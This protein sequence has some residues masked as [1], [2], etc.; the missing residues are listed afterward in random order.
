MGRVPIWNKTPDDNYYFKMSVN[1]DFQKERTP[2]K[3]EKPEDKAK[4]DKEFQDKANQLAERLKTEKEF[5]KWVY[6]VPR[7]TVEPML[8]ER[9]ELLAEKKEEAKADQAP[10]FPNSV[11]SPPVQVPFRPPLQAHGN[12]APYPLRSAR[13]RFHDRGVDIRSLRT[14]RNR[15]PRER[16]GH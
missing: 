12:K 14:G 5:E 16:S 4:L 3:D 7:Y 8:K 1:G 2:V 6:V 9:R 11:V 15:P 13:G 10:A